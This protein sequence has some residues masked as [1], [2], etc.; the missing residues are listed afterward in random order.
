MRQ[1]TSPRDRSKRPHANIKYTPARLPL[2]FV[3]LTGVCFFFFCSLRKSVQPDQE[4]TRRTENALKIW[5]L[6]AKGLANKKRYVARLSNLTNVWNNCHSLSTDIFASCAW[7]RLCLPA[8][9]PNKS[10]SCAFGANIST[11]PACP[12]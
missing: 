2:L 12:K 10:R 1:P 6:E 5:I 9:R 3:W 11:S 4:H 7:T 8:L